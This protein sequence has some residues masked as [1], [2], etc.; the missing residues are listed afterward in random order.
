MTASAEPPLVRGTPAG[1]QVLPF[2]SI[3]QKGIGFAV[4]GE[5]KIVCTR[6]IHRTAGWD[7]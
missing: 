7:I 2:F 1:D 4:G 3:S 6:N 5:L